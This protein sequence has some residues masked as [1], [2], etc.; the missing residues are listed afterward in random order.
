VVSDAAN[1]SA[2]A[3]RAP[4]SAWFPAGDSTLVFDPE[5]LADLAR[6]PR[7]P[8]HII[9]D[10]TRSMI[11]AA[12]GGVIAPSFHNSD[13]HLLGSLHGLYPEWL[14][15]RSFTEIHNVRF[16]ITTT[17]ADTFVIHE[18]ASAGILSFYE[19]AERT[20]ERMSHDVGELVR[21]L[22]LS[23]NWGVTFEHTAN[24]TDIANVLTK[25]DVPH[26]LLRGFTEPTSALIR[27]AV[28][29]MHTG[30]DGKL[31][32]RTHLHVVVDN[33][34]T[35]EAFMTPPAADVLDALVDTAD[36]SSH[37]ADLARREPITHD[38]TIAGDRTLHVD[39]RQLEQ[40][41]RTKHIYARPVRL[42]LILHT[43]TPQ[44]A[45]ET[46]AVG[47][48]FLHLDVNDESSAFRQWING[49]FLDHA[50]H[51]TALNIIRNILEGATVL[52]R[53]QQL[54]SAGLPVSVGAFN[55]Q[56][57]ELS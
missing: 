54:R 33:I 8:V 25:L 13:Y 36:L 12:T 14:G 24:D 4:F 23:T 48:S 42:G 47:A 30:Q 6:N 44:S 51:A 37:E 18:L 41:M 45:V 50:A 3:R 38:I 55:F 52:T 2:V 22:A 29:G 49:S 35:A 9:T 7:L 20:K 5:S 43:A 15:D 19:T 16:P 28:I 10:A 27:L 34:E 1:L 57:R 56:P 31:Q 26:V 46:L 21:S 17:A 53:A 32:R 40:R 39:V 11:G